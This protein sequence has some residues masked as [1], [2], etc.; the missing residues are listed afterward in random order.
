MYF[1]SRYGLIIR[2][3]KGISAML[4]WLSPKKKKFLNSDVRE[5]LIVDTHLIG[6][7]VMSTA[8]V[9]ALELKY[10]EARIHILARSFAVDVFKGYDRIVVHT[11]RV[12]KGFN[13]KNWI[14][15]YSIIKGVRKINVDLAINARGDIREIIIA[16][17]C[18][19]R[20]FVSFDFTGGGFLLDEIVPVNKRFEHLFDKYWA[21]SEYLNIDLKDKIP[22][23]RLQSD[24]LERLVNV[25]PYIGMHIDASNVLRQIPKMETFQI[26]QS[27]QKTARVVFFAGPNIS[28]SYIESVQI[29]FPN[30]EIWRGSLRE[31]MV[32]L[33]KCR[34]LISADSGQAHIAAALNVDVMVLGGPSK[35]NFTKPL[36]KNV[37]LVA[38]SNIEC[39]PCNQINCSNRVYQYCFKGIG[40]VVNQ[41]L[42]EIVGKV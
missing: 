41:K 17:F 7:L 38:L 20:S 14:A 8:F 21:L 19:V 3:L 32:Y 35:L 33:S 13:L 5:I 23:I 36:G 2:L 25:E 27:L 16:K 26:L 22:V 28:S 24:E 31:M 9:Q 12:Y 42:N 37:K 11:F 18:K 40:N 15:N 4:V 6:D 1:N 29:N 10:P 30:V 39:S 34:L